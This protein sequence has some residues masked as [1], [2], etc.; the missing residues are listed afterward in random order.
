LQHIP[1]SCS[2]QQKFLWK[3]LILNLSTPLGHSLNKRVAKSPF[4]G[5]TSYKSL[6]LLFN[7]ELFQLNC[8]TLPILTMSQLL[9]TVFRVV[10]LC[11]LGLYR[12]T[13]RYN[14]E[15][16]HLQLF[17]L[18]NAL[19]HTY[20]KCTGNVIHGNAIILLRNDLQQF[21]GMVMTLEWVCM[22]KHHSNWMRQSI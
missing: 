4:S 7:R 10:A 22:S 9:M 21:P 1:L 12:S 5:T 11:R 8:R 2:P 19:L 15:D 3:C 13:R 6:F 20:T 17:H 16:S 18:N 14:P